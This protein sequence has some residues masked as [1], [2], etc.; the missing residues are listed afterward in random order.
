MSRRYVRLTGL[1]DT[2]AIRAATFNGLPHVVVPVVMLVG[3]SVVWP[4]N[5]PAPE[6]VPAEELAIAPGAWNGRPC[7]PDHPA[8]GS[9]NSPAVLETGCFGM[10]FNAKFEDGRLKG[11]AWLDPKRAEAVGRDAVRVI[12]RCQAG[13]MVEVSVG[14]W[15]VTEA[16]SGTHDGKAY[17]AIWK[18]CTPDHLALLPEGVK[19][20]CSVAAG[21]GAPRINQ[22]RQQAPKA[23]LRAAQGGVPM[24][25]PMKGRAKVIQS[26]AEPVSDVG[27]RDALYEALRA[28]EP[29]FDWISEVFPDLS[30]VIY[31]CFPAEELL[32]FRRTYALGD[33]GSVTLNDDREQVEPVTS[34]KPVPAADVAQA[35][36]QAELPLVAPDGTPLATPPAAC[37][38]KDK[39]TTRVARE[40]ETMKKTL[41]D[42]LLALAAALFDETDRA[43]LDG[44][45]E[46]KLTSLL[47]K[48]DAAPAEE[49]KPVEPKEAPALTED[50]AI[51]ALPESL[52]E[53][54]SRDKA[55]QAALR[56]GLVAAIGRATTAYSPVQ[57]AAKTTEDLQSLAVALKVNEPAADYSARALA[58]P[59][60]AGLVEPPKPYSLAMAKRAAA[61]QAPN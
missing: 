24:K 21:C 25:H 36:G 46:E 10:V 31:T 45:T 27:L 12:E 26:L 35:K 6:F 43:M 54:I 38:C 50:E 56:A 57:L 9:A 17:E 42:R 28:V 4:S 3:D 37:G 44:L 11:E 47:A 41:V 58:S 16:S 39:P 15:V 22:E 53:M 52:R 2:A 30:T 33:N 18:S 7:M 13:E 55:T 5:A 40:G 49:E 59:S 1:A 32:W 60:N 51:A 23:K 8:E 61:A 19:G 14:A 34:Y 29:G 48:L 20:A